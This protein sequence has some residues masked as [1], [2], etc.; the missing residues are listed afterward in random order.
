MAFSPKVDKNLANP[1]NFEK[2][3]ILHY[4]ITRKAR[5]KRPIPIACQNNKKADR[6]LWNMLLTWS[7]SNPRYRRIPATS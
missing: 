7:C 3:Y 2:G 6:Y 4:N 1:N 5:R